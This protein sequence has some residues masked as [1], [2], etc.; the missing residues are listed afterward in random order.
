MA[1]AEE[2]VALALEGRAGVDQ[3]EIDVEKDGAR[4]RVIRRSRGRNGVHY[5]GRRR[6]HRAAYNTRIPFT[7]RAGFLAQGDVHMARRV[8][9]LVVLGVLMAVTASLAAAAPVTLILR[10][11][12]RVSGDL[13]DLNTGGFVVRVRGA[14]Q[15]IAPGEVA[16]IAFTNAQFPA[17]ETGKIQDGRTLVV[18]HSGQTFYGSLVDIGGTSP[19]RLSFRTPRRRS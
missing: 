12:D 5:T 2:P 14:E 15:Q 9:M 17:A 4:H 6:P 19:L 13:V 3:R 1:G 18:L 7:N 16:A 11:G 8:S 10:S